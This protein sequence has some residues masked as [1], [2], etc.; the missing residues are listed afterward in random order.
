[1]E[2]AGEQI[3]THQSSFEQLPVLRCVYILHLIRSLLPDSPAN[4][5]TFTSVRMQCGAYVFVLGFFPDAIQFHSFLT[6]IHFNMARYRLSTNLWSKNKS[7][8]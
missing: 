6:I 1:M 8:N 7:S 2:T 4:R 3:M 5:V